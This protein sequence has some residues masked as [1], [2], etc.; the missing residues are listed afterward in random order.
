M[1]ETTSYTSIAPN[2]TQVIVLSTN[3]K[4]S[5]HKTNRSS[6]REIKPEKKPIKKSEPP[7]RVKPYS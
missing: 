2:Q 4:T 1:N 5:T 7:S 3:S 6:L